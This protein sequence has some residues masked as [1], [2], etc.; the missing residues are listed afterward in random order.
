MFYWNFYLNEDLY[1]IGGAVGLLL[2]AIAFLAAW[3]DPGGRPGRG[4]R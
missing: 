1:L 3:F 4:R 2:I